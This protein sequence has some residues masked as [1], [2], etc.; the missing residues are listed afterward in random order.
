MSSNDFEDKTDEISTYFTLGYMAG[1]K[2]RVNI[3][4]SVALL[5][6]KPQANN[7]EVRRFVERYL[8]YRTGGVVRILTKRTISY[9]EMECEGLGRPPVKEFAQR[10]S[11]DGL[12]EEDE[13][14]RGVTA[15]KVEWDQD[16]MPWSTFLERIVG[17]DDPKH[18]AN[19]SL[20]RILYDEWEALGM[21]RKPCVRRNGVYGSLSSF[22]AA[23]EIEHFLG[24]VVEL[25]HVYKA[26]RKSGLS[27]ED[28][29]TFRKD[30]KCLTFL[31]ASDTPSC[32]KK[33]VAI[34]DQRRTA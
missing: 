23:I 7:T 31:E 13:D 18:A 24:E 8:T 10:K 34:V 21:D 5:L 29:S 14:R 33:M 25:Q 3:P 19:S 4:K 32:A 2:T 20:R 11:W 6:L 22:E 27:E 9:L 15:Y 17:S 1:R 26:I 12:N 30:V 28:V 16:V